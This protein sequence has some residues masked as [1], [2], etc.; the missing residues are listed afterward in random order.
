[1]AFVLRDAF[2]IDPFMRTPSYVMWMLGVGP[3]RPQSA[4]DQR[5]QSWFERRGG[6]RSAG[7]ISRQRGAPEH[8]A[9]NSARD[10]AL[11]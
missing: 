5:Q 11:V 4:L 9:Y 1:M 8:R 2:M 6:S 10:R 3:A 7:T